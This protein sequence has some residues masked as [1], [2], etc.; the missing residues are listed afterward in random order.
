MHPRDRLFYVVLAWGTIAAGLIVASLIAGASG[1]L[2]WTWAIGGIVAGLAGMVLVTLYALD[3]R[4]ALPRYLPLYRYLRPTPI[5]IG[6]AA[7]TWLLI[8]WQTWLTLHPQDDP[9]DT[10]PFGGKFDEIMRRAK[11]SPQV[12]VTPRQPVVEDPPFRPYSQQV[13]VTC[14]YNLLA[15]ANAFWS[16]APRGTAVLITGARENAQLMYN[17]SATFSLGST[18]LKKSTKI[19]YPVFMDGPNNTVDMDA[20]R[21]VPTDQSGI[22]IHGS[23]PQDTLKTNWGYYFVVR[24]TSKVPDGLAEYYKVPSLVWIEIGAGNP[25]LDRPSCSAG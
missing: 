6:I 21:L 16:R 11:S 23:D 24:R 12:F 9:Y 1:Q 19:D 13:G 25:W 22:I 2:S 4:A 5:M 17:L 15:A 20:P 10:R 14:A 18:E 8:G 3:K 7:L